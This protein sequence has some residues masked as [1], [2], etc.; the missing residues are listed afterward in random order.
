MREFEQTQTRTSKK[1]K[2]VFI[3][4]RLVK[5]T[6]AEFIFRHFS[7]S[8]FFTQVMYELYSPLPRRPR[9]SP[10]TRAGAPP[11][12]LR[13]LRIRLLATLQKLQAPR[14]KE[15]RAIIGADGPEQELPNPV[16][17]AWARGLLL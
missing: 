3:A 10:W 2:S 12:P 4:S 16:R 7:F 14:I 15:T 11:P 6:A 13:T 8:S 9:L 5:I 17:M 1:V